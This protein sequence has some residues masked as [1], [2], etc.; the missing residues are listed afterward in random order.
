[1]VRNIYRLLYLSPLFLRH[2]YFKT[3]RAS[4]TTGLFPE[5]ITGLRSI[6]CTCS[7]IQPNVV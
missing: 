4:T 2:H 7:M 3:I 5:S 6:S 1:M